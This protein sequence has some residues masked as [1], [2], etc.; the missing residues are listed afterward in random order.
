MKIGFVIYGSLNTVSG[1]Y[2]YDRKLVEYLHAQGDTVEIISLPWRNYGA[3]LMDNF[4]FRLPKDL[5]ILIQFGQF[6]KQAGGAY[7]PV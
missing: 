2:L 3:H 4:R 7:R 1:G 6:L 5:D